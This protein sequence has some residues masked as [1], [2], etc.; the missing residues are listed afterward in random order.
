VSRPT[1][2]AVIEDDQS[3]RPALVESLL[4][5]GYDVHDFASAEDFINSDRPVRYGCIVTDVHLTGLSGIDLKMF[6]ASW[7]IDVPVIMITARSDPG[8][9]GKAV[10]SGAMCLLSKPFETS[11]LIECLEKALGIR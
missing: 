4:S 8:L 9:E 10:T 5:F 1:L 11:A 6:L 2:I 3:F 7:G